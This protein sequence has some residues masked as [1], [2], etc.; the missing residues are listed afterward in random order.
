MSSNPY[1]NLN[2]NGKIMFWI[3][4]A[5]LVLAV[6]FLVLALQKSKGRNDDGFRISD[7]NIPFGF[8]SIGSFVIGIILIMVAV[9]YYQIPILKQ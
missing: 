7:Y 3:G 5:L 2:K 1:Q 6:V 8:L 9:T 4:V